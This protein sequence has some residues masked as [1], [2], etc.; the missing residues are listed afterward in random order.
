MDTEVCQEEGKL[1]ERDGID[2]QLSWSK[3]KM[4]DAFNVLMLLVSI[5]TLSD[6]DVRSLCRQLIED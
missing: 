3:C 2:F 5:I 6:V 1:L 4:G